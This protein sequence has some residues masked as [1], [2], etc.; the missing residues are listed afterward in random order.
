MRRRN[1]SQLWAAIWI[2]AASLAPAAQAALLVSDGFI[3]SPGSLAGQNGGTGWS[4]AWL[5]GQPAV[6]TI[7]ASSLTGGIGSAGGALFYDGSHAVSGT[8]ARILRQIDVGATSAAAQ[9]GVVEATQTR[10]GGIQP[11]IGTPGTTVWFGVVVNGGT[12]GNGLAGT[13][14]LAQLHFY[15]GATTTG[16]ALALGDNNKD[17]EAIAIGRG[18]ANTAWNFERTCAHDN[19]PG[20]SGSPTSYVSTVTFGSTTHWLVMRFDFASAAITNITTWLDPAAGNVIPSDISALTI[21]A[22]QVVPVAGL[23]FNWVELGGQT[24]QFS[25]DEVR[26]ATT[27]GELSSN[28]TVAVPSTAGARETLRLAAGPS[29]FRDVSTLQFNLPFAA[30]V[31]IRVLDVAGNVVRTLQAGDLAAGDH[32]LQWDGR[33]DRG[34]AA[35]P[36]VYLIRLRS[37]AGERT[38]KV[39]RV[40]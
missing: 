26:F 13:Q 3:Y 15:D 23:H 22:R 14:Y 9:A 16:P 4:T 8:G 40:P 24:S 34:G 27:F 20:G 39:L 17:G 38:V 2:A 1:S 10:F 7:Q 37:P 11:A 6:F 21:S 12:A 31:D 35:N 33:D 19:C 18:N 28:T 5:T 32:T 36:G 30:R 25:F 29:P